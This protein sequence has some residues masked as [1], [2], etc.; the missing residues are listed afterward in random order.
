[1]YKPKRNLRSSSKIVLVQSLSSTKS[2]GDRTFEISASE[3]W[4]KLPDHIKNAQTLV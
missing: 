4:N 2:Y 3:H 1:M